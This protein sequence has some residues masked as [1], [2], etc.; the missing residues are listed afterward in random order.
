MQT[1][2]HTD[3][4][5]YVD[6]IVSPTRRRDAETMLELMARASGEPATMWGSIVGFGEYHYRY[7]SGREGDCQAVGFASRK[8]ATV[9]YLMDGVGAHAEAL[10]RLGPHTTGVGCLYLK[11][12]GAVD[13]EVLHDI[14][15]TSFRTLTRGTYTKRARDGGRDSD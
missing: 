8:A 3:V 5:A 2:R 6:A 4:Q 13:L 11:D 15:A 9:V 1:G 14:V 7:D 12:V 10:Q